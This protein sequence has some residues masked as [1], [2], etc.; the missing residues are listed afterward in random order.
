MNDSKAR[1]TR[2]RWSRVLYT[3]TALALLGAA[4]NAT[5]NEDGHHLDGV[6]L[7]YYYQSGWGVSMAFTD[8]TL[9]YEWV[10][11]P[12]TGAANADVPYRSRK[13]G[14]RAYLVSFHEPENANYVTLL[15]NFDQNVMAGT[16]L[17]GYGGEEATVHFQGGVIETALTPW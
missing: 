1:F 9:S 7:T 11:G 5:A 10:A 15:L 8:G 13:V 14:P 16:A 4:S 3:M 2:S 12:P 6:S 17:L